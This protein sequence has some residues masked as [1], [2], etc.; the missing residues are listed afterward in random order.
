[1]RSLVDSRLERLAGGEAD[2]ATLRNLD[3]GAGLRIARGARLALRRL[4]RAE[5]DESDRL[6]LLQRLGDAFDER[7]DGGCRAGLR[8]PVSSAIFE[9]RSCLFMN[10]SDEEED[11]RGPCGP[12]AARVFA[13]GVMRARLYADR[14]GTCQ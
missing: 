1:M 11:S 2:D 5:T 12:S 10:A 7:I 4:E 8:E 3:R 13:R 14:A 9:M 6:A